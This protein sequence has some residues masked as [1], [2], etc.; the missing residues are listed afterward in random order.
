MS[1]RVAQHHR[2]GAALIIAIVVLAALLMLGLPFL[3]SQ[4]GSLSGT[5]SYAHSELANIGQDSAQSMGIKAGAEAIGY[6][7][8]QGGMRLLRAPAST[9]LIVNDWTSLF[10]D[11]RGHDD[12]QSGVHKMSDNL[13]RFDT[14]NHVFAL[15]G[16]NFLSG[17]SSVERDIQLRRYPIV[18]GL[19]IEDESG[20]LNPNYLDAVAW[21]RLL[22]ADAV[23]IS[24]WVN[25]TPAFKEHGRNQLARALA[26]LRYQLAGGRITS[27]DQLLL[28]EPSAQPNAR[29][30]LT[31]SELELLRPYLSLSV[32]SQARGGMIDLGT[33]IGSS[34]RKISIDSTQ[35]VGLIAF[36]ITPLVIGVGT[37]VLAED[38]NGVVRAF[39][40]TGDDAAVIPKINDPLAIDAPPLVNVHQAEPAVQ[41]VFSIQN[42]E[43]PPVRQPIAARP[44][45]SP[46]VP[47][48]TFAPVLISELDS[49]GLNGVKPVDALLRTRSWFELTYPL[50]I[51]ET[52]GSADVVDAHNYGPPRVSVLGSDAEGKDTV[53]NNAAYL[54]ISGDS[55]D[56]FPNS[57]QAKLFGTLAVDALPP[58]GTRI[59]YTQ[60]VE[61]V[62]YVAKPIGALPQSVGNAQANSRVTVYIERGKLSSVAKTF[63][64]NGLKF[65]AIAQ[66]EQHPIG[67]AS[68]GVITITS[69][70]TV[71]DPAGNQTAQQ[72]HR[73]IAQALP[74][75]TPLEARWNKQAAFHALLAQ[76]HGS[77]MT[78]FPQPYPRITDI[79]PDDP[80]NNAL[81]AAV[82]TD[83]DDM[84]GIRPAVMRTLLSS[85]L[86]R[87]L[88]M[89]H[90]PPWMLPFS[91]EGTRNAMKQLN[92]FETPV[93]DLYKA[94]D[95]TPEG[96]RLDANRVLSYPNPSTGLIS[97][98]YDSANKALVQIHGRQFGLW[99]RPDKTWPNQVSLLDMRMPSINVSERLT[100]E[101]KPGLQQDGRIAD[102]GDASI[103]NRFTLVY[104]AKLQQL[105]LVL[106][107]GNIPH[108]ADYGPKIPRETYGR[109]T[110]PTGI[111]PLY[112]NNWP[113]VNPECLGSDVSNSMASAMA[114]APPVVAIEHR[115]F[116]GGGFAADE[117]HLVQVAYSSNQPGGMSIIVDGLVG[118]DVSRQ[119]ADSTAMTVPGD[120]LTLPTLVLRT[121]LQSKDQ[122]KDIGSQA[123]YADRIALDALAFDDNGNRLTKGDAVRRLLPERGIVRIGR[124]YISYQSIDT[125][126][127]LLNCV[128]ARRQRTDAG[129]DSMGQPNWGSAHVMENHLDG[130]AVYPGGFAFSIPAGVS[131]WRGGCHLAQPMPDGDSAHR[132][133]VWANATTILD[134]TSTTIPLAGTV[135]IIAQFPPRGYVTLNN[136]GVE[137]YYDN[138]GV[139]PILVRGGPSL[140]NIHYR[141]S[142]NVTEPDG[143][144]TSHD[145]W[146]PHLPISLTA[147]S[148]VVLISQEI[149]GADPKTDPRPSY[150]DSGLIQ[151]YDARSSDTA[152]PN[153]GRAEWISYSEIRSE[154]DFFP[155]AADKE[156]V[157]YLINKTSEVFEVPGPIPPGTVQVNVP[158]GGFWF[159]D[160]LSPRKLRRQGARGRERTAFAA[161]DIDGYVADKYNFPALTTRVIP[162]QTNLPIAYLLEAGDV[163]TLAPKVLGVGQRPLQMCVRYSA[164]DAFPLVKGS[165]T[166][167][168]WNSTN[169]FFAFTEAIPETWNP[170]NMEF[171]LL[172]WPCWTPDDD[173]RQ[174][175]TN[176]DWSQERLGWVLPWGNAYA[177]DFTPSTPDNRTITFLSTGVVPAGGVAATI[178]AVHGGIQP[179]WQEKG[180]VQANI[181]AAN[182]SPWLDDQPLTVQVFIRTNQSFFTRAYGIVE[183][184][185]ETFAY[186]TDSL[187]DDADAKSVDPMAVPP[188]PAVDPVRNNQAWLIGRSLLGSTR[189]AHQGPEL[190]LHLPIGPVAEVIGT[191]PSAKKLEPK[192][193]LYDV[194]RTT[195]QM[196]IN[197]I[198]PLNLASDS[199]IPFNPP[200]V[201]LTS[202]NGDQQEMTV[203]PNN[204]TAPWLR[205]MYNTTPINWVDRGSAAEIPDLAPLAIGWWPRYP[206]G[207]PKDLSTRS[208]VERAAFL[209]CRSY[210]WAGFPLRFHDSQ[211]S[212]ADLA[213]VTA[214]STGGG[215]FDLQ[216]LALDG[217]MDWGVAKMVPLPIGSISAPATDMDMSAVF[218]SEI[219]KLLTPDTEDKSHFNDTVAIRTVDGAE[220]RIIWT[221]H[222]EPLTTPTPAEWLQDTALSGNSAPMIG[223]VYLRA[224]APNKIISVER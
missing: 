46:P 95:I 17:M 115:Y 14:R 196:G 74:Q 165:T 52:L 162:V 33:V 60:D 180:L 56:H 134:V 223:P 195:G 23:K 137:A 73:V 188:I 109:T 94:N 3:F 173:L 184:G 85:S 213:Q 11:L 201:L 156:R 116:V 172:S 202:R 70:A 215:L 80:A 200:A 88:E 79:M 15:P 154:K 55:L 1:R 8:Q 21:S 102:P 71:T 91:S 54:D 29:R 107:P 49:Y 42:A 90:P 68:Q 130:D 96:L 62:S 193:P 183:I 189:R 160:V 47:A 6:H 93:A 155:K 151:L 45:A 30:G 122:V 158:R 212:G 211:F 89:N 192:D 148:E 219:F 177:P 58:T 150:P 112:D 38:N 139:R 114:S 53:P 28:A 194:A 170:S 127:A 205:G 12:P 221:Y 50:S 190:V 125:D 77:L 10:Y 87:P 144:I 203:L 126:G 43:L 101:V 35:P 2:S 84:A 214:L 224:R 208:P 7:W 191:I 119:P 220:L 163:V 9:P 97:D 63:R 100:G 57:G 59:V 104:D 37:T 164:D 185:G 99:I 83:L 176:S 67:I 149:A 19:T 72:Q 123:L 153:A 206:S 207:Y 142:I 40:A 34:D 210:A 27:L 5:R 82:P 132:Y 86:V 135:A 117:W 186:K 152:T 36:P 168:S 179:G 76:R 26:A 141:A 75:E 113:A 51:A 61:F 145:V 124:E 25:G 157:S 106:N 44:M 133:Q 18:V 199:N 217:R 48:Q 92:G 166:A 32:P 39:P 66:R 182:G 218:N 22:D 65:I 41:K 120:H 121:A 204:H 64:L 181:M 187:G 108:A 69:A 174:L 81:S 105:V 197:F 118:R 98:S 216:A 146:I 24:D 159:S 171:K 178:D 20:K 140:L 103:S 4:S 175:N 169:R 222:D 13:L 110:G 143:T 111:I 136:N 138:E 16:E 161:T 131:W 31:R 147:L 128:R 209:R 167:T 78:T 198:G 129:L